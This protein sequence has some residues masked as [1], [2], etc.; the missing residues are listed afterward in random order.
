METTLQLFD[1]MQQQGTYANVNTCDAVTTA[2]S[3]NKKV[4]TALQL[5]LDMRLRGASGTMFNWRWLCLQPS[6]DSANSESED[7]KVNYCN[8]ARICESYC[9]HIDT[10]RHVT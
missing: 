3:K 6:S 2:C 10:R 5:L 4:D 9:P 7:D 1:D 8:F